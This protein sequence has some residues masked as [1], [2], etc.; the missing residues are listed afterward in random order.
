MTYWYSE[1][2]RLASLTLKRPGVMDLLI[3]RTAQ[4]STFSVVFHIGMVASLITGIVLEILYFTGL[5]GLFAG[6]GWTITWAHGLFGLAVAVGF[7]GIL[8]RF[9]GNRYFRL[10]SGKMF[11]VDAAFIMVIGVSG[12]VLLLQVVGLVAPRPGWWTTIH[13]V[14]AIGWLFVSLVGNGLVAHAVATVV[15][16]QSDPRSPAAFAAFSSACAGCGRCV[17]ACPLYAGRPRPEEAPA[18]KVRRYLRT[19]QKGTS[20]QQ[21]KAVAEDV[22]ACTL[23]GLCVGICPYSF[24]HYDLYMALLAEANEAGTER[25]GH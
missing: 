19:L 10:A 1:K 14:S 23:C 6:W 24:R 22:Y 12:L 8:A 5:A 3:K 7:A 18:L 20:R 4:V 17:E 9:A 11:Y 13:L 16:G 21:L 25:A 15:Y 2:P